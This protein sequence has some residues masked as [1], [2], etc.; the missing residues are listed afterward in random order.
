MIIPEILAPAGSFD[1]LRAAVWAGADAVYLGGQSFNARANATN[2]GPDELKQAVLLAHRAGVKVY[3]T[4]NTLLKEHELPAALHFLAELYNLGV[5]AVIMQDLGL[6]KLS[7]QHLPELE[8]HASTQCTTASLAGAMAMSEIG[9]QRVV[10]A[11][12]LTAAQ[13]RQI[14]AASPIQTEV[15]VHGALCVAYSG[16]CLYSSMVGGR[17]GNRGMCAQSCRLPSHLLDSKRHGHLLSP[18]DLNLIEHIPLLMGLNAAAW[19][20][21]GRARGA[22]YVAEVVSIYREALES[23]LES[24]GGYHVP[25]DVPP[26]LSQAFNREFTTGLMLGASGSEFYNPK[27]PGNQGL[28]VGKVIDAKAKRTVV[29]LEGDVSAGDLLAFLSAG[30]EIMSPTSRLSGETLELRSDPAVTPLPGEIVTR[31]FDSR[32]SADLRSAY[33]SHEPEL[34]PVSWH[35]TG[36]VGLPLRLRA[37]NGEVFVTVESESA[38]SYAR[39]QALSHSGVQQQLAKL[40]G[41]PFVLGEV[42]YDLPDGLFLPLSELNDCRRRATEKLVNLVYGQPHSV[43]LPVRHVAPKA[44]RGMG[45]TTIGATVLSVT[46][47]RAAVSAGADWLAFGREWIESGLLGHIAAFREVRS[48]VNVPVALRLPRIL[49]SDEE[50]QI[51]ALIEPDWEVLASSPGIILAAGAAVSI[52]RGDIGLNVFNSATASSLPLSSATLSLELNRDEVVAALETCTVPLEMIV[53]DR[54]LL[55]VHENCI[56]G[57]GSCSR[58]G[59]CRRRDTLHDRKGLDFPVHTDY[60]CRSYLLNSRPLS[61]IGHL[62]DMTALGISRLRLELAGEG[63]E[64]IAET[65]RLYRR[66]IG[67]SA[68][69]SGKDLR[70]DIIT[71]WGELTRGHWQRGVN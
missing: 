30:T 17:S 43:V 13:V 31:L 10:L 60:R 41:T 1:A 26:R 62:R 67:G 50:S 46:E 63:A 69:D 40:G 71:L 47:A 3:V 32:R 44:K 49:H 2:F 38:L 37:G 24:P 12:E 23:Y 68:G 36:A 15:F 59:H 21:E 25:P 33:L 64:R 7:R 56:L 42:V 70:D 52:V 6:A 19:K 51:I 39:T 20:I 9:F 45:K 54:S 29:L 61:L 18:R 53:H 48:S 57:D 66:S 58:Q 14:S 11:R 55:M 16:Q 34:A 22:D 28:F 5:D 35:I 8:L 27:R 65:V 4:V